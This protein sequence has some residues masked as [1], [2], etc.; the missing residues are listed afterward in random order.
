MNTYRTDNVN[1]RK[2]I[3]QVFPKQTV[4]GTGAILPDKVG[5]NQNI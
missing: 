4:D 2:E 1:Y 3:K 5:I